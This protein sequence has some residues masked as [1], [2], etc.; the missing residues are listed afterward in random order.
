MVKR[1]RSKKKVIDSDV[2]DDSQRMVDVYNAGE[3]LEKGYSLVM[4]APTSR[5]S[6]KKCGCFIEK[7][8][9]KVGKLVDSPWHHGLDTLWMCQSCGYGSVRRISQLRNWDRLKYQDQLNI[10]RFTGESFSPDD[11]EKLRRWMVPLE[12]IMELVMYN[13]KKKL[14]IETLLLNN[15]DPIRLNFHKKLD[16]LGRMIADQ[17]I[18]G[19]AEHCR[20]CDQPTVVS[21]AFR[22]RCIGWLKSG[23]TRC[24]FVTDPGVLSCKR[25]AMV[26]PDSI[27]TKSWLSEW[28]LRNDHAMILAN[29]VEDS[30]PEKVS[31]EKEDKLEMLQ[32]RRKLQMLCEYEKTL[33]ELPRKD[34]VRVFKSNSSE[35]P[36][37][38]ATNK[39]LIESCMA[40]CREDPDLEHTDFSKLTVPLIKINFII[41]GFEHSKTKMSKAKLVE[42]LRSMIEDVKYVKAEPLTPSRNKKTKKDIAKPKKK[43]K[44]NRSDQEKLKFNKRRQKLHRN[45]AFSGFDTKLKSRK[46]RKK[47]QPPEK[48]SVILKVALTFLEHVFPSGEIFIDPSN[49]VDVY[50]ATLSKV[51]LRT[52][53][54]NFYRIQAIK[55]MGKYFVF[56]RWGETGDEGG[57]SY[58]YNT[59]HCYHSFT[60]SKEAMEYFKKV[61]KEK[62]G[63]EF[64]NRHEFVQRPG[65]YNYVPLSRVNLHKNSRIGRDRT[66][67]C[68]GDIP[69]LL[70]KATKRLIDWIFD[71]KHAK[72]MLRA[73]NINL[74]KMPLGAVTK[75]R[76]LKGYN[77]L[78]ELESLLKKKPPKSRMLD[79]RQW[80]VMLVDVS[81]QYYN[82][83]PQTSPIVIKSVSKI[84]K[85]SQLLD[86]L[87]GIQ[88]TL[89]VTRRSRGRN[90]MH[91]TDQDYASL[92][93]KLE[94][95]PK[96]GDVWNLVEK[97]LQNTHGTTH[98]HYTLELDELYEVKRQGEKM[99]FSPH[100]KNQN[101][102]LLWHGSRLMNFVGILSQGLRIAPPEAPV[103]GYMFGKGV[104]FSDMCSKSANYCCVQSDSKENAGLALLCEVA[105]GD[106]EKKLR[107]D[108]NAANL[109][110][111]K[112]SVMGCGCNFPNDEGIVSLENGVKVPCGKAESH[113]QA[114]G[115]ELLYN[116][117]IVYDETQVLVRYLVKLRFKFK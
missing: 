51:N 16:K 73:E 105:L 112:Q 56:R 79:Y 93:C 53:Y 63:N 34:L 5:A 114:L 78:K 81:T 111:G 107:A 64:E 101:R 89:A 1:K 66:L 23:F 48:G 76:M 8:E 47:L 68:G 116:E 70:P 108:S 15:I 91:P 10:R 32:R 87:M 75:E 29:P 98:D 21:H 95:L 67:A 7:G 117:Y 115:G 80:K 86:A 59:E 35:V 82:T 104:Y 12:E 18:N 24:T 97:Y 92:K 38:S 45:P 11:E 4:Y 102:M 42:N 41:R 94:E 100:A 103:S 30:C 77:I 22:L 49:G 9:P 106:M 3:P 46:K 62:S 37:K 57:R 19:V 17:M 50:N 69:S 83:I 28:S 65:C 20:I 31:A 71:E 84:K 43:I 99:R 96:S 74:D 25:Y 109:P 33:N 88:A 27:A 85:Q 13:M 72:E 110:E 39:E 54:N 36:N 14:M 90:D 6:C 2:G 61:F 26:I 60:T 44:R 40:Q 55:S 113:P 52:R 58:K